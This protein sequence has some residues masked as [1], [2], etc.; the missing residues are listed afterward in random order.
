MYMSHYMIHNI[1]KY[2][3]ND[4][5][6]EDYDRYTAEDYYDNYCFQ[7]TFSEWYFL[8]RK[9]EKINSKYKHTPK[10]ILVG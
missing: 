9:K 4:C 1:I 10:I 5:S 7:Y 3:I 6:K 2:V 8:Y